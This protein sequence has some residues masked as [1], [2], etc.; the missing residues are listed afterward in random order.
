MLSFAY[1]P[2]PLYPTKKVRWAEG[3]PETCFKGCFRKPRTYICPLCPDQSAL[4][5]VS[6]PLEN[7][8]CKK[9]NTSMLKDLFC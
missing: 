4:P 9:L 3:K 1:T 7:K 5:S 6:L 8:S 2:L